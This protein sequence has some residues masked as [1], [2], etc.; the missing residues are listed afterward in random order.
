MLPDG[1]DSVEAPVHGSEPDDAGDGT[2]AGVAGVD[3]ADA[4]TGGPGEGPLTKLPSDVYEASKPIA[5]AEPSALNTTCIFPDV[6][7][8]VVAEVPLNDPSRV[9]LVLVPSY[10]FSQS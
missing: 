5:S 8:T 10:T 4:V 2:T 3:G 9:P 6:A 7:V 1:L